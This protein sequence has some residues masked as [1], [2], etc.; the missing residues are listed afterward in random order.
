MTNNL[1]IE[2]RISSNLTKWNII[3]KKSIKLRDS[4]ELIRKKLH[5]E[6]AKSNQSYKRYAI[7]GY[8]ITGF[9]LK[10]DIFK[11]AFHEVSKKIQYELSD[12]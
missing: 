6:N 7:V 11:K 8:N 1:R 4:D 2:S 5:E 10:I 12:T 9:K 3:W